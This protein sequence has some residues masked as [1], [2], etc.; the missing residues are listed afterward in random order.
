[1]RVK[2]IGAGPHPDILKSGLIVE[3][4]GVN[5]NTA[6][7]QRDV[8]IIIDI[9][10]DA[11]GRVTEGVDGQLIAMIVIPA[12]RWSVKPSGELDSFGNPTVDRAPVPL[13]PAT[14]SITLWPFA[15]KE[16]NYDYLHA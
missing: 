13:D 14:V 11:S 5:V 8:E 16:I 3:V 2:T 1:M 10:A 9:R 6:E 4:E 12:R 15:K 7:R